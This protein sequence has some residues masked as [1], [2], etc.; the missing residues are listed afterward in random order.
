MCDLDDHGNEDGGYGY[1]FIRLGEDDNDVE[2]SSNDWS[3][4]LWMIRKID[5]PDGLEEII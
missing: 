3:I 2:T 1:K 4:E 5:I